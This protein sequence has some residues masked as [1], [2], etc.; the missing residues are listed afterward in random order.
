M[1][2]LVKFLMENGADPNTINK[3]NTPHLAAAN[4]HKEVAQHFLDG[5]PDV[6]LAD[7]LF[8]TLI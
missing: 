4:G 2:D 5:V 3:T 8:W 7:K 6:R 1:P